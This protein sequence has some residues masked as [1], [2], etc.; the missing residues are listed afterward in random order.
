MRKLFLVLVFVAIALGAKAQENAFSIKGGAGFAMLQDDKDADLKLS[1]KFGLGYEFRLNDLIGIEPSLMISNKGFKFKDDD[2][3]HYDKT[4]NLLYAEVPVTCNFHL[5]DHWELAGGLYGAYLLNDNTESIFG[6]LR[7]FEIG[8]TAAAKYNFDCG[9]FLGLD[10]SVSATSFQKDYR[11]R[12]S[13][14]NIL[15]GFRF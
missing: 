3:Y 10:G 5:G 1:W 6:N 7:K 9:L 8:T 11:G 2:Y 15:V 14:F 13:A 4:F 12:N